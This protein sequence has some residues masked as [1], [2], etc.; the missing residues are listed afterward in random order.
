ML[1]ELEKLGPKYRLALKIAKDPRF[2]RLHCDRELAAR[3]SKL[4][5]DSGTYADDCLVQR[6][7]AHKCYVVA[8]V[9]TGAERSE[10]PARECF[11]GVT[12]T[13]GGVGWIAGSGADAWRQPRGSRLSP[14]RQLPELSNGLETREGSPA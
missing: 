1:A 12:R 8:T 11:E 10:K 2:D 9:S 14:A 13:C 6:V 5:P 4:M 3:R 7:T